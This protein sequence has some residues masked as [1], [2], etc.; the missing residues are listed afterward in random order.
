MEAHSH[1]PLVT[2]LYRQMKDIFEQSEQ[3]MYL[4][5]DDVHKV[6]NKRF[7]E[8]L[9]YDSPKT[10]AAVDEP[11]PMVFVAAKSRQALVSAYQDAVGRFVGTS[12]EVAW[13]RKTG[14]TIDTQVILVP[15]AYDGHVFALHYISPRS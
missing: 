2:G 1:G 4:Y 12:L 10:W 11:F 9:G 14:A 15:V 8:L 3:A 7:A 5:L 6:C 13:Q